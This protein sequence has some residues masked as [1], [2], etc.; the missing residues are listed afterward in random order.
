M[1]KR[2]ALIRRLSSVETLGST[3][4]I[5]SDKTGTLTENKMAARRAYVNGREVVRADAPDDLKELLATALLCTSDFISA[6]A[7]GDFSFDGERSNPTE[8][9]LVEAAL[10]VGVDARELAARYERWTSAWTPASSR[11][12]TSFRPRSRSTPSARG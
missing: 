1:V 7:V 8:A 9:A 12:A 3:S 10:D 4:V 6:A 5:C 11:P 2:H